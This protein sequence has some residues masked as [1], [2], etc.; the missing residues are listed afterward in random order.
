MQMAVLFMSSALV[1]MANIKFHNINKILIFV[2]GKNELNSL[3]PAHEEISVQ[4][5]LAMA[6]LTFETDEC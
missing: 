2:N 6:E 5:E 1:Q 3:S 4:V